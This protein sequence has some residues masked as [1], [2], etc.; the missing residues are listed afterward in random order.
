M[1]RSAVPLLLVGHEFVGG[2]PDELAR[3]SRLSG[4]DP[5]LKLLGALVFAVAVAFLT[6]LVPVLVALAFALLVLSI[7]GIGGREIAKRLAPVAALAFFL[8][9]TV[10]IFRG[11][12][13]FAVLFFRILAA[14]S[15][16]L[17]V[18]LTTTGFD[19]VRALRRLGLPKILANVLLLTLRYVFLFDDEAARM[20]RARQARGFEG[21]GSLLSREVLTTLSYTA[22]MILVK[23]YG[24]SR[25][26][27]RAMRSRHYTGDMPLEAGRRL[28]APDVALFAA[29][30]IVSFWSLAA[31]L[32]VMPWPR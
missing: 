11:W 14:T 17:A 12:E 19:M 32:G 31:T 10:G 15:L 7:T 22:G 30:L 2:G 18:V 27:Y 25:A 5:T 6:A 23:A 3:R 28:R 8:S 20:K 4:L 29:V 1:G 21:R 26:V 24:R 9:L 13:A 16:L